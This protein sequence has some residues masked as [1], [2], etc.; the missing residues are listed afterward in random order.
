M[1]DKI[2]YCGCDYN[3]DQWLETPEIIDQD[4]AMMQQLGINSVNL[5]IFS[6]SR[7]EPHL[8]EYDFSWL[9]MVLDKLDAGNI[10]YFIATPGAAYPP[11]LAHIYPEVVRVDRSGNRLSVVGRNNYCLSSPVLR[12]RLM[13]LCDQLAREVRFRP[14]LLG[15]HLNNELSGECCCNLCLQKWQLFLR[16]KYRTIDKL[17]HAW[18]SDFSS[19]RFAM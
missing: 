3:P 1:N 10:Q 15:W 12:K 9:N 8:G 2:F 16:D 7:L 13:L 14:G 17:N 4:I 5:G 6:W 18:W 19:N 11:Y